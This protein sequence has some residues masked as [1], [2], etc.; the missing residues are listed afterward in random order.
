ML[1]PLL[2][3]GIKPLS[4]NKNLAIQAIHQ[5]KGLSSSGC[6]LEPLSP[7]NFQV[8]SLEKLPLSESP[9]LCSPS[10]RYLLNW[11][12]E[13]PNLGELQRFSD[14]T[15]FG[16]SIKYV[17]MFAV[18][19]SV[20]SHEARTFVL[21]VTLHKFGK[22]GKDDQWLSQRHHFWGDI[23]WWIL[24]T[25]IIKYRELKTCEMWGRI[26]DHSNS[27]FGRFIQELS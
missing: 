16:E 13:A 9:F 7:E 15:I 6:L 22:F 21:V 11:E 19:K 4:F 12:I 24:I 10:R 25:R 1:T 8:F 26:G 20:F 18:L 14:L 5:K 2:F 17:A 23:S 3:Q 27:F